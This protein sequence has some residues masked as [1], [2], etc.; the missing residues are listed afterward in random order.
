MKAACEDS[1]CERERRL[2]RLLLILVLLLCASPPLFADYPLEI[3]ELKSRQVS[4]MIPLLRPFVAADGSI[5]GMNNQ[6]IIRTSPENLREIRE[7]LQRLD[8]PPRRLMI[9]VRQASA[10]NLTRHRSQADINAM[11]GEGKVIVGQPG[12]GEGLRYR[13]R[14]SRTRSDR[15]ITHRLRVNEGY[16]AFIATGQAVPLPEQT[17]IIDGRRVYQ[18]RSTRY[19][20]VS[21]GF[22]VTPRLNGDQVTLEIIP[23]MERPTGERG[24]YS[25]QQ[26][27]TL[28]SGP[29]GEWI[30]VGG[31]SQQAGSDR[32]GILNQTR[33]SN[34][35]DRIIQ[36][37]V[38]EVTQ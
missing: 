17:T 15:D 31:V 12:G 38:E 1:T 26:A 7:I 16:P 5:A 9:S 36:V 10:T 13:L 32:E 28:L 14:E 30:T 8:R 20:Q 18:Q 21:S 37:R 25:T 3:I 33:T 22:Y 19:R 29:L 2:N 11:I 6:L 35:D 23:G 4:E 27:H 24:V 34:D